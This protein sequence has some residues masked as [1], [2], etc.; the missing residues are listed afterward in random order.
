MDIIKLAIKRP[1]AVMAAVFMI[2]AFGVV[3]VETIP[4]QLTPD[5]R[6][7]V[8]QVTTW[9]PGAAPAEV[10]KEVTNRLEEELTGIEGLEILSSSS[11]VGRSRIT[12]EFQVG[13]NMERAFM[14][15]SNRLGRVSDL[16]FEAKEPRIRTS[17][18]DD[19]PI[20]RFAVTRLDGNTQGIETY[21]DFVED[22]VKERL[23]RVPGVSQ[24]NASGGSP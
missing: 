7:P 21:G 3:A 22:V 6:R 9:W 8:L 13:Q 1:T 24:V 16:P 20:A 19:R 18:S 2:V 12:L 14:L 4:I 11:Q 15:L 10:E 17:G 5:V 23:E